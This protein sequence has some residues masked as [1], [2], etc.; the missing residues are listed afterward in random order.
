MAD[1]RTEERCPECGSP[2]S[3]TEEGL[4]LVVTCGNCDWSVVTTNYNHPIFDEEKYTVFIRAMSVDR[5]KAMSGLSVALGLGILKARG[6]VDNA[7]PVAEAV[8]ATEVYRLHR[9]LAARGM[10][11]R[12][13]PAFPWQLDDPPH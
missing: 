4:S 13:V 12:T 11:I 6:V 10:K 8:T 3:A 2:I 7:L 9:T 1:T 5:K